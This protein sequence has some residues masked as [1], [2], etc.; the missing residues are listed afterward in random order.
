[1]SN[2][3]ELEKKYYMGVAKRLPV[4]L[5]R[6]E[7]VRV[8]DEDGKSYLDLVAGIAVNVLGHGHPALVE[9]IARQARDL[10]HT[11]NLYYTI[12]QLELAQL[13]VENSVGEQVFFANSGAEANEGAFKLARKY[14]RVKRNGAYEILSVSDSFHGRTLATIAA[15]GQAKFQKPFLPMPLGFKNVPFND[16][17]ALKAATTPET[18][19]VMLEVVQGESGVHV[20]DPAYMRGVRDWC[21]EAGLL[22]II[23]EI[24]TGMGRTGKLFGYEQYGVEPDVFT[25]A[26]GLAG[27]VPIGAFLAKREASVF[28]LSDHGSTFGGNPLACAAGVATVRTV[29]E[30]NLVENAASVG[31]YFLGKMEELKAS[32]DR[33]SE[34]RGVG[35][36]LA[37]DLKQDR[38]GDVVMAALKRGVI[39]NNTGPR[40]VRMVPPLILSEADADEAAEKIGQ[41]IAEAG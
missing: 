13:L 10:I 36:M 1:M 33:V 29:L 12:P 14:G 22:L 11:S 27:G 38:A 5:V 21:D 39:L 9:A 6:G 35:L 20:A 23:D 19:A 26:K 30:Q 17:A 8:W 24:Q 18:A 34:V 7:G 32:S 4:V 40:T 37:V 25:M 16:L 28:E 2:W 15:T 41:A 3:I 31:R